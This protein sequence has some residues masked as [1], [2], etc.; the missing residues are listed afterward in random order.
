[1]KSALFTRI[2]TAYSLIVLVLFV[3]FFFLS[4]RAV[5]NYYLGTVERSLADVGA[6]ACHETLAL[7]TNAAPAHLQPYIRHVGALTQKRISVI[8]PDGTVLADSEGDP[9]RMENHAARPE[10]AQA[11]RGTRGTALRISETLKEPL[12]Y[13]ALPLYDHDRLLAVV[14]VSTNLGAFE[15]FLADLRG[16]MFLIAL[17]MAIL[18]LAAI[19]VVSRRWSKPIELLAQA[20]R[21]VAAGNL[22]TKVYVDT[23]DETAALALCFNDMV[24]RI[25]HSLDELARQKDELNTIIVNLCEGLLVL[26]A[27]GVVTVCNASFEAL[28]GVAITRGAPYWE[29]IRAPDIMELI[30]RV[31]I[32]HRHVQRESELNG[33][34]LLCNGDYAASSGHAVIT[35][36]DISD[37]MAVAKIKKD[38][39]TNVSHELRTPLTS[40]KGFAETLLETASPADRRYVDIILR[41]TER[42]INI[43]ADLLRLSELEREGFTLTCELLDLKEL[44]ESVARTFEKRAADKGLQ[45][46]LNLPGAA[47]LTGDG[48]KLEQV[49]VNLLDNA[50]KYTEQGQVRISL[51]SEPQQLVAVIEDTG[52]G[53]PDKDLPHVFERFYVVDKSR[54]RALGGTGLGLAIAKHIVLL[55]H[56]TIDVT[57]ALNHGTTF[58]VCLPRSAPSHAEMNKE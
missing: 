45:L 49:F 24:A 40:I 4:T 15:S 58:T 34:H 5:R 31:L 18:A 16:T 9:A 10:V 42:L 14:R 53:I 23:R 28:A 22:D 2:L 47:P 17:V 36:H 20:A 39:V 30:E 8:A 56:G 55:H 7:L 57:S 21:A 46:V 26:Q 43:V 50:I 48:F 32:E 37:I 52:A 11:L 27:D 41:N 1:M 25:K 33:R 44:V 19:F 38:F 6:I 12:L 35:L 29:C 54:A 51:R 13:L 3:V